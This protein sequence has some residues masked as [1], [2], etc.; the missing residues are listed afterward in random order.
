[1]KHS[2]FPVRALCLVLTVFLL[3]TA[4]AAC[5]ASANKASSD[6]YYAETPAE[7]M[8]APAAARGDGF[9]L[10]SQT[11]A[12]DYSL[13]TVS[14]S[15]PANVKLIY[16]ANIEL[17]STEFD[18]ASAGLGKLVSDA[19]GYFE[20][21]SV[22]NYG[23]YRRAYYTVRVPAEQFDVF[24]N[25][26]GELCQVNNI[27]RSAQD[28]SEAYYDTES[29]LITQQTKLERL[30]ELLSQAEDM[31][32]IITLESAI[33]ETELTIESL[34]GSLR[35]YDSLVGYSTIT[36]SL[37]EVYKYTPTEEPVIGFG[38]KLAAAFRSGTAGFVDGA[39]S[40]LLSLARNWAGWLLFIIIVVAVI[41][42][43]RAIA[44]R[45]RAR[46]E[47]RQNGESAA[48]EK[49]RRRRR[50]DAALPPAETPKTGEEDSAK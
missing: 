6:G 41:L 9:S 5:G 25:S 14:A 23:S 39:Q 7:A 3:C 45:R 34:T 21:S 44:R 13:N 19:G 47:A 40:F 20:S 16:T 46:R 26:V 29:R 37:R 11:D 12:Y 10:E 18:N 27:S 17:E 35:K 24:C 4:F 31:E 2:A 42:I 36:I 15:L 48:P 49:G 1:M 43:L 28:I 50:T 30:Q 38:A 8:T 22:D 33:S 32:D